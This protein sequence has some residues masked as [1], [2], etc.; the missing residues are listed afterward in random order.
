MIDEHGLSPLG[1]HA[2]ARTLWTRLKPPSAKLTER[3]LRR[4]PALGRAGG[5]AGELLVA[6]HSTKT[7][8]Q[9][10]ATLDHAQVVRQVH[11]RSTKARVQTPATHAHSPAVGYTL[12]GAQRR[13]ECKLRRPFRTLYRMQWKIADRS[14]KARAQTPATP[15]LN[16]PLMCFPST[17]NEGQSTISSDTRSDEPGS[18]RAVRRSTKARVQTPATLLD[19][20]Q[21]TRLKPLCAT[22]QFSG[23]FARSIW[24]LLHM[25]S[26]PFCMLA[27]LNQMKSNNNFRI[28]GGSRARVY[29]TH[30]CPSLWPRSRPN[31]NVES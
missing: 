27:Q 29:S 12:T 7:E 11:L 26:R 17:L 31:R 8:V 21:D 6:E 15:C 30:G 1:G 19:F 10:P 13:P 5:P 23:S 22:Y 18:R 24:T 14:A 16:S 28:S 25:Q 4:E 3:G 2:R 20:G 9:T